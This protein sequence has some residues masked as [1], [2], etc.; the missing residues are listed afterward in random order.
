MSTDT[1]LPRLMRAREVSEQTGL[2][3]ARI[4]ELA[5]RD[6]IPHVR[7]GRSI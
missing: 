3:L 6:E 4:Y 1:Q 2:S 7:V 5:R